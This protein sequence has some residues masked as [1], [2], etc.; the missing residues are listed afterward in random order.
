MSDEMDL[1]E[2]LKTI[3]P[4]TEEEKAERVIWDNIKPVGKEI[5]E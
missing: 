1:E 2:M 5:I 3:K 4:E